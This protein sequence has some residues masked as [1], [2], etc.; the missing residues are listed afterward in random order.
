MAE[1]MPSRTVLFE[2][3]ILPSTINGLKDEVTNDTYVEFQFYL[4][5]LMV[6]SNVNVSVNNA[7]QFYLVRLMGIHVL[8]HVKEHLF[9][10]Y[11]VRLMVRPPDTR[12]FFH[13]H[14]NST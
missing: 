3:S 4:V 10:F 6:E 1:V 12:M 14:F 2:I 7:F 13:L 8:D 9:Q 5:R 11:L